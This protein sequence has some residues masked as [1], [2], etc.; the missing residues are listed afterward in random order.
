MLNPPTYEDDL[1]VRI[2]GTIG[3]P[4]E[5]AALLVAGTAFAGILAVITK[6]AGAARRGGLGASCCSWPG[7]STPSR[8]VGLLAL[9]VALIAA[10]LLAG[11]WRG[12]HPGRDRARPDDVVIYFASFAGLDARDRVTTVEGGS[13]RT[14]IWKVGWRM[15]ED[16]PIH[17]I[18]SGNFPISSIHYLLQPGVLERDEFIIDTPKVAHNTYLHI[19][20]ELGIVGLGAVPDDHRVRDQ[21]RA[22]GGAMVRPRRG[23]RT[24]SCSP[25]A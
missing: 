9:C 21:L 23:S 14:D 15:V 8:A 24:W 2:S 6:E 17:G 13:G 1:T 12:T 18:G 3:D 25:A 5:L 4:N 16:K 7:S 10:C 11:R 22:E 19:L 20:A